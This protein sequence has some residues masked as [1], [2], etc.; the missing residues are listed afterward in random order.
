M[1][2]CARAC[3]VTGWEHAAHFLC[4]ASQ[5]VFTSQGGAL[6]WRHWLRQIISGEQ[7]HC[8]KPTN[9]C[10]R[11]QR[12]AHAGVPLNNSPQRRRHQIKWTLTHKHRVKKWPCKQVSLKGE[13]C[14]SKWRQRK[15]T[16]PN[17]VFDKICKPHTHTHTGSAKGECFNEYG[18]CISTTDLLQISINHGRVNAT[19][20]KQSTESTKHWKMT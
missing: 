3:E 6:M 19:C 5:L 1:C 15:Q 2:L 8:Y 9:E 12:S 14:L 20:I 11:M 4:L 17:E 7:M 10:T 18:C 16:Q 13:S